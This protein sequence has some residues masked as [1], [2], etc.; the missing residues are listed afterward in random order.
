MT[1][2]LYRSKIKIKIN[3][4]H[5]LYDDLSLLLNQ[6]TNWFLENFFCERRLLLK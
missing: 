6:Y 4:W 5:L 2:A 1:S 3:L